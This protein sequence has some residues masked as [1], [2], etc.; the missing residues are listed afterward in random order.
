MRAQLWSFHRQCEALTVFVNSVLTATYRHVYGS[1][2]D[3]LE[4][5]P[6]LVRSVDQLGRLHQARLL[7]RETCARY[8]MMALGATPQQ[9]AEEMQRQATLAK[10]EEAAVEATVAH[11]AAAAVAVPSAPPSEASAD[12]ADA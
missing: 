6:C 1:S 7:S 4:V 5:E 10:A 8:T 12:G 9:M 3:V 11:E 2:D